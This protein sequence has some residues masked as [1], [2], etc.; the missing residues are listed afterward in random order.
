MPLDGRSRQNS[1]GCEL[2]ASPQI[3]VGVASPVVWLGGGL[4]P[5]LAVWPFATY[6]E[7]PSEEWESD[8]HE[9]LSRLTCL[10]RLASCVALVG[11]CTNVGGRTNSGLGG[12]GPRLYHQQRRGQ[13]SC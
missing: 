12:H 9:R 11:G 7:T 6:P 4:R 10:S 13:H 2:A 1:A 5:P 8:A 3:R